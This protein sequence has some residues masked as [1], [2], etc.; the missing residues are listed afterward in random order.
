MRKNPDGKSESAEHTNISLNFKY[1]LGL[2][3]AFII[4]AVYSKSLALNCSS[5]YEVE[6]QIFSIRD[7]SR[8]IHTNIAVVTGSSMQHILVQ[9]SETDGVINKY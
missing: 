4:T 3:R 2:W 8:R 1:V 9:C 5:D 7:I 6:I